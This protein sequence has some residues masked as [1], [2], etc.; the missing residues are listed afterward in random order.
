MLKLKKTCPI[1]VGYAIDDYISN[2]LAL[3]KFLRQF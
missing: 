3:I 1:E 2:M